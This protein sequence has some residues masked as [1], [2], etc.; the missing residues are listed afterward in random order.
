MADDNEGK[1]RDLADKRLRKEITAREAYDEVYRRGLQHDNYHHSVITGFFMVAG[2]ILCFITFF[3]ELWHVPF[4]SDLSQ[5]S[6]IVFPAAAI[7]AAIILILLIVAV[8]AQTIYLRATKGGT[9]WKGES[10]TVILV[11]EGAYS[12]ARHMGV[13]S[14]SIFFTLLTIILSPHVQFNILSVIGNIMVFLSF[15]YTA[16][17]GDRL[18]V[19]KWGNEYRQYMREVPRYNFVSGLWRW[20]KRRNKHGSEIDPSNR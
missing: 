4:L 20:A 6:T 19:L 10:E 5:L 2:I 13:L 11:K 3:A 9:G 16:V 8:M 18:N 7:Y 1:V 14:T 15:Y 17:E 12:I